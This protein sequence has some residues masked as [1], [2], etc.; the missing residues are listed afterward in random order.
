MPTALLASMHLSQ[1]DYVIMAMMFIN[2]IVGPLSLIMLIIAVLG[3]RG[4]YRTL[5][6]IGVLNL[7]LVGPALV[8]LKPDQTFQA[9]ALLWIAVLVVLAIPSLRIR[10]FGA[11]PQPVE[12][13]PI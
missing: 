3:R 2:L 13:V 6:R 7:I 9:Q 8:L 5:R 4:M 11:D 12:D 1:L 10:I